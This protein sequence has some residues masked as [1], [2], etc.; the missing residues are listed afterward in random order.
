MIMKI[1][2]NGS[3]KFKKRI[4]DWLNKKIDEPETDGTDGQVLTTDGNGGRSWTTVESDM[5]NYYTKDEIDQILI[6]YSIKAIDGAGAGFHSSI[7]RGKYLGDTYTNEQKQA[8]ANGSFDDL[9]VGD[10]WTIN[11]V[12]WRIADFDY[13]YNIGDTKFTKHHVVIVP[14]KSLYKAQMNSTDSTSGAY[15]GSKMYTTNLNDARTAFDNAFGASFIPV[16][17][18]RY[19]S[20][21]TNGLTSGWIWIDMRVELMNETQVNG[22]NTWN[23]NGFDI[24]TQITQ[25][26]MFSLDHTKIN[27]GDSYW[28]I[29]VQSGTNFS[30]MAARGF[31][32][33]DKATREFGVRPFACLVGDSE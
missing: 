21:A 9:F 28:L 23:M 15:T 10:Y 27:T 25:F 19:P 1:I 26:R 13:Y 4:V 22:H 31:V 24:G 30:G 16:H 8:I 20:Q 2:Y 32:F 14:D 18:G 33:G 17:R 6:D 7:Y 29:N 3:D 11:G 5:S 12:N